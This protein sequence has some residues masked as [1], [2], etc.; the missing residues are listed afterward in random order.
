MKKFF[1]YL[2]MFTLLFQVTICIS[3]CEDTPGGSNGGNGGNG[4]DDNNDAP[5]ST[6]V[7]NE[8]ESKEELEK[9]A[10]E[11]MD[12]FKASDFEGILDLAEYLAQ[13]CLEY[14]VDDAEEMLED[15]LQ[16]VVKRDYKGKEEDEYGTTEIYEIVY[17]LSN[18]KGKFVANEKTKRLEKEDADNFSLHITDQN[19]NPCE[20]SLTTSGNTKTVYCAE[21]LVEYSSEWNDDYYHY[22]ETREKYYVEVPE[23]ATLVMKQNGNKLLEVVINTDLSSMEGSEFNLEN[24]QYSVGLTAS[25]NGY[26]INVDK[27][28][29]ANNTEAKASISF[30]HGNKNLITA[31]VTTTPDIENV[32]DEEWG[33]EYIDAN[34]KNNTV[35]VSILNNLRIEGT[36]K[37]GMKAFEAF[38]D[39]KYDGDAAKREEMINKSLDVKVFFNNSSE[40]SAK[41]EIECFEEKEEGYYETYYYT[42]FVPVIVF[43]DESRNEIEDFF[44]EYDFE[45]TIEAFEALFEEFEEMF[46]G[47]DFGL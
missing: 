40:A 9:I 12:E 20:V 16:D 4:G 19:G 13:E 31:N 26:S 23:M 36:C 42:E 7:L 35:K 38:E 34:F 24:D 43:N 30:K 28:T 37:N 27:V 17:K 11:L 25:F 45:D 46:Y 21:E 5:T 8:D 32:Y 33:D 10:K 39:E 18:V 2:L 14:E 44:N 6:T 3:S 22:E 15:L 41:I 1:N 29:Y 47:Y